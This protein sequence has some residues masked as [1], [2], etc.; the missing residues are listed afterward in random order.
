MLARQAGECPICRFLLRECGRE[1][2]YVH[3][4]GKNTG[5]M[6]PGWP[7]TFV[8]ALG[9][10]RLVVDR[11]AGTRSGWGPMMTR[12]RSV[13]QLCPVTGRLAHGAVGAPG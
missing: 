10:G 8:A 9:P 5:R 2:R 3:G 12:P 7:Y 6:I 11:A 4:R 13:A 1:V